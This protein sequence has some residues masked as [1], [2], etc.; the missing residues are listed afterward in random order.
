MY[1]MESS[2]FCSDH[3]MV[4]RLSSEACYEFGTDPK[5]RPVEHVCLRW[6]A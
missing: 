6:Y 2:P 3:R 5:V 4:H 1:G